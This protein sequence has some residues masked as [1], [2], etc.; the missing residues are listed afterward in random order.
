MK[1]QNIIIKFIPAMLLTALP[2]SAMAMATEDA[3]DFLDL[4]SHWVGFTSLALFFVAYL[5]VMA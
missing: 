5:F 4:T 3:A 1:F 2:E